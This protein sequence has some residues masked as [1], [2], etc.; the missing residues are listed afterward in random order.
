MMQ[1]RP[2]SR[3]RGG[4]E[5]VYSD[6][7]TVSGM[8]VAEKQTQRRR[9]GFIHVIWT[10]RLRIIRAKKATS[11]SRS[12]AGRPMVASLVFYAGKL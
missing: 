12:L 3:R 9:S 5:S 6:P 1:P 4:V 8:L 2:R 11:R 7:Y 10:M